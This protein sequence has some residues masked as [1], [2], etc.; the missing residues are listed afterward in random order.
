[1]GSCSA[2]VISSFFLSLGSLLFLS[3]SSS[4]VLSLGSLRLWVFS[5]FLSVLPWFSLSGFC[6]SLVSLSR[7]CFWAHSLSGF[8]LSLPWLSFSLDYLSGGSLYLWF[9]SLPVF[10]LSGFSLWMCSRLSLFLDLLFLWVLSLSLS[11]SLDSISPDSLSLSSSVPS[12]F[13]LSGF[14]SL[15]GFSLVYLYEFS[16]S[17]GFLS[18]WVLYANVQNCW[19]KTLNWPKDAGLTCLCIFCSLYIQTFLDQKH[20]FT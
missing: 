12:V 9:L 14:L 2:W 15:S 3:L 17:R 13:N 20:T 5:L 18:L 7:F 4:S 10:S 1:M 19:G 6:L 11:L 8:T 16:L